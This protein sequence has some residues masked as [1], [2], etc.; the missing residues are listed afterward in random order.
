MVSSV[1]PRS[2]GPGSR[3]RCARPDRSRPRRSPH[4][5]IV[6]TVLTAL[7]GRIRTASAAFRRVL[8]NRDLRRL[9]LAYLAFIVIELGT[10]IA[11]LVYANEATGPA[12]IG[13]VAVAQLVPSAIFAPL[14]A[15]LADR[16]RR[17]RVLAVGYG[18]IGLAVA[19]TGLAMLLGAPPLV[20]YACAIVA[21][22]VVTV[23][24]PIQS[25]LMPEFAETPE[26][27]TSANAV[28]SIFEAWGGLVGPLAAGL[29]M[30]VTGT[31]AVF[32]AAAGVAAAAMFLV[33]GVRTTRDRGG[34]SGDAP[35]SGPPST[36]PGGSAPA[37]E[38]LV[39]DPPDT[40][41][42]LLDGVRSVLG[43]RDTLVIVA[44]LACHFLAIGALDVLIVVLATDALD[45]G[46]SGAGY[47]NAALGLGAVVGGATTL[48]LAGSGRLTAWLAAGAAVVGL[49]VGLL[50][51]EP[52]FSASLALLVVTG[53]GGAIFDIAGRTFLQRVAPRAILA[54]AFGLVEGFAMAGMAAGSLVAGVAYEIVG[55]VGAM[56]VTAALVPVAVL[57]AWFR[58]SRL[59]AGLDV[60]ARQVAVLR[61]LQLFA[62]VPAPAVEAAARRLN[63]L[64]VPAGATIIREGEPGDRFYIVDS[65]TV[66]VLQQGRPIRSLG[67]GQSFGQIAL[68]RD[69]PRTATVVAMTDVELWVLDRDAFLFAVA[70]SS[71]AA[72]ASHN[73]AAA[74]L[75]EDR[76]RGQG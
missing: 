27:L 16:Y 1:A 40:P 4:G 65:G 68:L 75:E 56:F 49:G 18:A 22:T 33:L 14:G 5:A 12:S 39:Y 10:W 60:P 15:S 57:A 7:T 64:A 76:R 51:T 2:V 74:M 59:E 29:L 31:G 26:E 70:G 32:L 20:V 41:G 52:G 35:T 37:A 9:E 61:A 67:P 66:Q 48:A 63:R 24:R 71:R 43:N 55:L 45:A 44:L 72:A 34:S 36:G 3:L 62:L 8:A 23:P 54:G 53:L 46:G 17:E 19:A 11:V 6:L 13:I 47:L 73:L 50:G 38:T 42:R 30:A 25:S 69:V 28:N 58:L 21:A